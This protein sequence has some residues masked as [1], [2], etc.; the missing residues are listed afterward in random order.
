MSVKSLLL[1][2]LFSL[3][4]FPPAPPCLAR[5]VTFDD[6]TGP[7]L[8]FIVPQGYQGLSWTNFSC[9]NSVVESNLFG[10]DGYVLGMVSASNVAFNGSGYPAEIDSPGTNF[11]FLSAYLTGAWNN[12]LNIEV[13]GYR[14]TN[15][16]YDVTKVVSATSPTLFT[17]DYLDIDR[18]YFNSYGGEPAFGGSSRLNFV[19]DNFEFEFVPEP[20]SLLLTALGLVPLWAYLKRRRA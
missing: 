10:L 15:L 1:P 18:L 12:N 5:V 14:D 4:T 9:L 2:V 3:L 16:V 17:F 6:L 19:V 8:D 7:R 20:S 11:N 13:R